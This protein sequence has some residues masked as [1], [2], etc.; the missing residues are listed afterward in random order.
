MGVK[1]MRTFRLNSLPKQNRI[2]MIGEFYDIIDSLKNRSE[3]RLFFKS[4]LTGDEIATFM[5]RIETAVLLSGNLNYNEIKKLLGVSNNKISA[6]QKSLFQDDSGYEIIIKR[7]LKNRKNR[8]KIIKKAEKDTI[9]S[10]TPLGAIRKYPSARVLPDLV[11]AV[12]EKLGDNKDLEKEA[13]LFT[14]SRT[15]FKNKN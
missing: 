5:R 9:K 12:M 6:V 10:S 8:L 11:D 2:Q 4:L 14:P 15:P 7:L 3:V 13:L 1:I